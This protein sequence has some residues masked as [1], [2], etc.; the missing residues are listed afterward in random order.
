MQQTPFTFARNRP[1]LW[2]LTAGAALALAACGGGSGSDPAAPAPG[3]PISTAADRIEP[4]DP[5]G[6]AP[7]KAAAF[8]DAS[9]APVPSAADPD[10]AMPTL[11]QL[12]ALEPRPANPAPAAEPQAQEALGGRQHIG[13][14]RQLAATATP[15]TLNAQLQWQTT[16]QGTQRATLRFRSEGAFGVRLGV[17]LLQ[18]L[19][20]GST[21][22]FYGSN[23]N[24]NGTK[25][26]NDN[27]FTLSGAELQ[28]AAA[29]G[30][31]VNGNGGGATYWSPDFG[32]PETT[33][34]IELPAR[35]DPAQLALA[36]PL[37]SHFFIAP[38]QAAKDSFTKALEVG[39]CSI[40][41]ACRPDLDA[42]SRSVARV[43]FVD[44]GNSFQCSGTLLNDARSSTTPYLLSAEHCIGTQAAAATVTTD[45]FYRAASC[46]STA[47]SP[48]TKRVHGGATLLYASAATDTAF[49]RLNAPAPAGSVFAGSFLGLVGIGADVLG[50]HQPQSGAQKASEGR[51]QQFFNCSD[52]LCQSVSAQASRFLGVA[53][54]VGNTEQ[55]SSGSPLFVSLSNSNARYVSGQLLGGTSSCQEPRGTD[56]YGRFDVAFNTALKHWLKPDAG[57]TAL[58]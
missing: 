43:L 3:G 24:G 42:E 29:A 5:G 8:T 32:G 52:E 26:A 45:W 56:F 39:G 50:L 12:P 36:V 7:W 51:V 1:A 23:G 13:V 35:A 9:A 2:A 6:A 40:D 49:M 37:L 18:S 54:T 20:P 14:A 11:V 38:A 48:V 58:P 47:L 53:W 41:V 25:G 17:Q 30:G 33:L 10:R 22:R 31:N 15:A 34:E 16:Q 46:N 4:Y 28:A 27:T 44:Q 57:A 19:P 55:G 21:L